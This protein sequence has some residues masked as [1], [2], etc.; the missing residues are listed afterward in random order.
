MFSKSWQPTPTELIETQMV[1]NT[2]VADH[3]HSMS[4]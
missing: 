3:M 1:N 4:G 2:T